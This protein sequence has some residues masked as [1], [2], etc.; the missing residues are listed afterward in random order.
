MCVSVCVF[1]YTVTISLVYK[2]SDVYK[3]YLRSFGII[4]ADS[5]LEDSGNYTCSLTADGV[6]YN[7]T[8]E[9]KIAGK[10]YYYIIILAF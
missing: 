3:E 9:V 8:A 1:I 2:S 4:F 6:V 7:A 10:L 5:S